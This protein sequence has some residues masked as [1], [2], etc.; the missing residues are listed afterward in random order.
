MKKL[1]A[2][3]FVIGMGVSF[4]A[5]AWFFFFLP[6]GAISDAISGASGDNCVGENTK[7]GDKITLKGDIMI[8]KSLSGTSSRC[9][10]SRYPIRAELEKDTTPIT[11]ATTNASIEIPDNYVN[12]ELNDT[13]KKGYAVFWVYDK[14]KDS[15]MILYSINR[16]LIVTQTDDEYADKQ[17][18]Q[19]GNTMDIMTSTPT[20]KFTIN[21]M[22]VWQKEITG[23]LK[24]GSYKKPI[25]YLFTMY[26][27]DDEFLLLKQWTNEANFAT[28]KPEYELVVGT[29]K[30]IVAAKPQDFLTT[31]TKVTKV[32]GSSQTNKVDNKPVAKPEIT[33]TKTNSS[34]SDG[35]KKLMELK[36]L[37]D[38]GLI[39]QQDYDTKKAQILKSM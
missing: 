23:I 14:N 21:G 20:N 1:Y 11:Q 25:S 34:T 4:N 22:N 38:K 30:G 27:G 8:V 29:V 18:I 6:V 19:Q 12:R 37:L 35:A 7:V 15:S 31:N 5:N 9:S 10:D 28:L 3:L 36:S 39:N 2:I 16:N 32:L 26:A 33:E 17:L 24:T 13:Q